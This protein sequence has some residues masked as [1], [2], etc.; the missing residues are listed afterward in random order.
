MGVVDTN[1]ASSGYGRLVGQVDLPDGGNELHHFGWNACSSHLCPYAPEPACGAA[2]SGG[3]GHAL[4]ADPHHRHQARSTAP[5]AGKAISGD[6]VMA[7]TGYA[8]PHT[9]H[10]G[11]DG[12]YLNALG[13]RRRRRARR[14]LH[15][16]P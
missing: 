15:A 14:H 6:T 1:P 10:C 2:L 9:V 11:P 7:A 4:I 13:A 3:A 12:I 8:V 16:R 5:A